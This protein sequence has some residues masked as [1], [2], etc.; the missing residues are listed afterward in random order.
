[1][2]KLP[3]GAAALWGGQG[4]RVV[5]VEELEAWQVAPEQLGSACD[6]RDVGAAQD[7]HDRL[8]R[9]EPLLVYGV[10]LHEVLLEHRIGPAAEVYAL[11]GLNAVADGENH[12]EVVV[13]YLASYGSCPL[14]LN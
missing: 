10:A 9:V 1:M 12:V 6:F 14:L 3:C 2:R 5:V 4:T 13:L 11:P 7:A 8:E